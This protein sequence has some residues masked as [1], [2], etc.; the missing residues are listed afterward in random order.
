MDDQD[1]KEAVRHATDILRQLS[2]DETVH[3]DP[4]WVIAGVVDGEV[5]ELWN[6]PTDHQSLVPLFLSRDN[7]TLAA[8]KVG[9]RAGERSIQW[10]VRGLSQGMLGMLVTLPPRPTTWGIVHTIDP[11][12]GAASVE[13]ITA[14]GLKSL[15]IR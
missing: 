14:G 4:F 3:G 7:A 9:S 5:K 8:S 1:E 6:V 2:W 10:V 12:S 11:V 15:Y 13:T